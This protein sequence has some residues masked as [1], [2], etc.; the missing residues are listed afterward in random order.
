MVRF[1]TELV[2]NLLVSGPKVLPRVLTEDSYEFAHPELRDAL[3][4]MLGK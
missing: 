4:A 1:F 2:E 3:S